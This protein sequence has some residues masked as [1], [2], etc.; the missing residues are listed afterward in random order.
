MNCYVLTAALFLCSLFPVR[1]D[2][3][4]GFSS[5]KIILER[6]IN[7]YKDSINLANNTKHLRKLEKKVRQLRKEHDVIQRK[8]TETEELLIVLK[9]IDPELYASTSKV[10]DANGTLTQVFVRV[11][12][13][14]DNEAKYFARD[15]FNAKA[16]TSLRPTKG[17]EHVCSSLH[18]NN[19]IT[20]TIIQGLSA[21]RALG[22]EFA[23]VLYIV[24]N[25]KEYMNYW[26]KSADF[27]SGHGI[28]DPSYAF[29]KVI[30][31]RFFL[32]YKE[33]VK[34]RK[35]KRENNLNMAKA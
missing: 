19:S 14:R 8:Y 5:K 29:M 18:G 6:S 33:F 28:D 9:Q 20:I 12:W 30:E 26:K 13:L 7:Q 32:R 16:Y 4:N 34:E 11:V 10:N 31:Q 3:L 2:I 27:C 17:N 21:I 15:H 1:A 35:T 25:L 24:P 22:H 23:H